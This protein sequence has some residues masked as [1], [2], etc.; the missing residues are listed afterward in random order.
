M[1][2]YRVTDTESGCSRTCEANGE[3]I[4]FLGF[5]FKA[6]PYFLPGSTLFT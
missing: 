3:F 4:A 2:R 6:W 1:K 5:D